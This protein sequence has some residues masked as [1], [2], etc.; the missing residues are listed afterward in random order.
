MKKDFKDLVASLEKPSVKDLIKKITTYLARPMWE[1][2]KYEALEMLDALQATA[3]DGKDEKA[4]FYKVAFQTV[5]S[6]I[7]MPKEQFRQLLLR[8]VGDK[9]HER[10]LDVVT[11]VEKAYNKQS[12]ADSRPA[13]YRRY[14]NRLAS[15][16]V[17]RCY[18]CGKPGHFKVNC[19][20]RK[21]DTAGAA[22]KAKNEKSPQK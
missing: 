20:L 4:N 19:E 12:K 18:H 16:Q 15:G 7:E 11:K 9:D 6:K 1:F 22:F 13:P 14:P 3:H 10:V 5:R 21:R 8:L 2:N 17:P